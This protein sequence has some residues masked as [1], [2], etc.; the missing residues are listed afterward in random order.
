MYRMAGV[1][2]PKANAARVSLRRGG[3]TVQNAL[4]YANIQTIDDDF[5]DE[6][7]GGTM[8]DQANGRF[9][10]LND[11]NRKYD[12]MRSLECD[13]GCDGGEELLLQSLVDA[14][15][16]CRVESVNLKRMWGRLDKVAFL[17]GT[18]SYINTDMQSGKKK[19]KKTG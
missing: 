6:Q 1:L 2:A 3:V 11:C 9:A 16:N 14:S 10:T 12:P 4:V 7:G 13:E 15:G 5:L 8:W 18:S 17:T 19:Q